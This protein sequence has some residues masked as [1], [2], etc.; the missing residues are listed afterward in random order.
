MKKLATNITLYSTTLLLLVTGGIKIKLCKDKSYEYTKSIES[1][2]ENFIDDDFLVAAHRGFSSKEI[3]NTANSITLAKNKKYIDYIEL[4]VRLTK[5]NNLVLSHNNNLV[6]GYN[7]KTTISNETLESLDNYNFYYLNNS[8]NKNI[9]NIFNT[10][11]GDIITSRASNIDYKKYKICTL[12]EGL[13][14]CGN[15][16]IIL[17]LKFKNNT[18]VYVDS[19]LKELDGIDTNN[20]IFQSSDLLS[21]LYLKEK[22]P[23]FNYL[24]IIKNKNSLN[25]IDLFDNIGLRKNLVSDELVNRLLDENKQIAVWTVNSKEETEN[26]INEVGPNYKEIIYI[27]DYPDIVAKTL[28]DKEKKFTKN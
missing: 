21:L 2:D 11:D 7:C 3:E 22:R 19:L 28:N 26:I 15:K 14:A 10:T 18:E 17:D 8:F 1:F 5:D 20:I 16:K 24:A 12:N 23:D 27:S 13:K 25:Y 9:T 4:D 6:I